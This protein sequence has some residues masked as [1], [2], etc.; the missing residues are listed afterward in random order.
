MKIKKTAILQK[1]GKDVYVVFDNETSTLHEV[2]EV[3][4]FILSQID[5]GKSESEIIASLLKEYKVE[6][7]RAQKDFENFLQLLKKE[8]LITS[9]K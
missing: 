1:L 2:N 5:T 6:R 8:N 4:F 9:E 7:D 3:A